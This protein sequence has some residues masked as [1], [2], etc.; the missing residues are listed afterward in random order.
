[1]SAAEGSHALTQA[2]LD[3]NP[4]SRSNQHR[5]PRAPRQPQARP[6]ADEDDEAPAA[7]SSSPSSAAG[8]EANTSGGSLLPRTTISAASPGLRATQEVVRRAQEAS[9]RLAGTLLNILHPEL[10]PGGSAQEP[11]R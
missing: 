11:G 4:S 2:A 7:A 5:P 9:E 10:A 6:A 8:S 1:M 3:P